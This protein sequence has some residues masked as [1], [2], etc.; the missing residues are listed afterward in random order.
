MFLYAEQDVNLA[1]QLYLGPV[2]LKFQKKKFL[3]VKTLFCSED[4]MGYVGNHVFI[5]DL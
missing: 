3:A 1:W 4:G 2:N 5:V